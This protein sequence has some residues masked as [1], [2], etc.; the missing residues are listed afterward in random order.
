MNFEIFERIFEETLGRKMYLY[1]KI[2]LEAI[3]EKENDK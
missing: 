3:M 1:E 2:I